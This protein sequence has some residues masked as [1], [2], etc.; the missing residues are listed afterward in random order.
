MLL[1]NLG[2]RQSS[3]QV[4]HGKSVSWAKLRGRENPAPFV[5]LEALVRIPHGVGLSS[6]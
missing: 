4:I 1:A 6:T 5:N 3:R 2:L